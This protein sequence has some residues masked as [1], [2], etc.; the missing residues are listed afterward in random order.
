MSLFVATP[1][2]ILFALGA[3]FGVTVA[4]AIWKFL[5][6]MYGREM[7]ELVRTEAASVAYRTLVSIRPWPS[8]RSTVEIKTGIVPFQE[9]PTLVHE[10]HLPG[11]TPSGPPQRCA[12]GTVEDQAT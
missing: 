4:F 11:T 10:P 7:M 9:R 8:E 3:L 5:R 12:A 2:M 6:L 1:A